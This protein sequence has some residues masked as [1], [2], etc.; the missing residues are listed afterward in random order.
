MSIY[1]PK[2]SSK[3]IVPILKS[4]TSWNQRPSAII[5]DVGN[6]QGLIQIM[7][8]IPSCCDENHHD[9]YYD[10]EKDTPTIFSINEGKIQCYV[11]LIK[12]KR[13]Q[14]KSI[15]ILAFELL[16]LRELLK[17]SQKLHDENKKGFRFGNMSII[18][19]PA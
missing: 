15:G 1:S 13:K 14:N 10:K 11:C 16:Q 19:T 7:Y 17:K 3:K 8:T 5:K 4:D 9:T 2:S 18:V 12:E 6:P